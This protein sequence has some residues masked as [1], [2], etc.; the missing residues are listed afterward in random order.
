MKDGDGLIQKLKEATKERDRR[1]M[2]YLLACPVYEAKLECLI[3]YKIDGS[4]EVFNWN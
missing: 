2:E 3:P 4:E 1:Y